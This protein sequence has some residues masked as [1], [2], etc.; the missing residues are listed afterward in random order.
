MI[1]CVNCLNLFLF[2][3]LPASENGIRLQ[4]IW[5][6][7]QVFKLL[8]NG[9]NYSFQ[10]VRVFSIIPNFVSPVKMSQ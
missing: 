6:D 8:T 2:F 4:H 9:T 3:E 1:I 10:C 7:H 5:K